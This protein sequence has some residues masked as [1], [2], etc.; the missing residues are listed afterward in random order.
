MA[1]SGF[2]QRFAFFA[3][4]AILSGVS[5]AVFPDEA[6]LPIAAAGSSSGS[7]SGNAASGGSEDGLAGN[8]GDGPTKGGVSGASSGSSSGG[9]VD[10]AGAGGAGPDPV[11]GAGGSG[12]TATMGGAP[13]PGGGAPGCDK[14][15][16][17]VA[18]VNV[19]TYIDQ[20]KESAN[21]AS[22]DPL[23]LVGGA[24]SERR[25]LLNMPPLASRPPGAVL[26]RAVLEL[27]V[28]SNEDA[29]ASARQL[30]AY[31]LTQTFIEGRVN[32]TNY[33]NGA[34]RKWAVP[35]G[36]IGAELATTTLSSSTG[37]GKLS[38]DVTSAVEK[39]LAEGVPLP[40][41]IVETGAVP[42]GAATL[43]LRSAEADADKPSLIVDF[44]TP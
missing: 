16:Q 5:C 22:D 3:F 30:T 41:I 44:C 13:D 10:V 11:A 25:V 42:A 37:T 36:D 35:G 34:S 7:T 12:S 23:L 8:G 2:R 29:A 39:A 20:T 24:G 18:S 14:P 33:G 1:V 28:Q 4:A 26:L 27:T 38:F 31:Q 19:D 21:H 17:R 32:W 6:I 15:M 40:V 9:S 43:A